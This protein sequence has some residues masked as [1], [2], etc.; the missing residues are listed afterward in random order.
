METSASAP[1]LPIEKPIW[2]KPWFW[3]VA[4]AAGCLGVLTLC[5]LATF[6]VSDEVVQKFRFASRK[7]A[8]ADLVA[9]RNALTE[10]ATANGGKF[11]DSLQ[12]LVTPDVQGRTYLDSKK[13]PLDPWGRTYLYEPPGPG[14]PR[15]RICSY[16]KD[17]QPGGEGDDADLDSL[18]LEGK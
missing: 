5:I 9:L 8:E 11:P 17:G 15:P 13:V 3:I 2:K 1:P 18:T 10:Y 6:V 12:G 7:K 4:A 16:G 14:N